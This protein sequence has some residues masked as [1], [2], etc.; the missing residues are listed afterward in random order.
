MDQNK[1]TND[2]QN[3]VQN[4]IDRK[5]VVKA[6]IQEKE[7]HVKHI[8][9]HVIRHIPKVFLIFLIIC[10]I[11]IHL[12]SDNNYD[13]NTKLIL[14]KYCNLFMGMT[15]VIGGVYLLCTRLEHSFKMSYINHMIN[16][17]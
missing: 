17:I 11:F 4:M 8:K 14:N 10:I 3:E 6:Y 7:K 2:V 13:D 9:I 16:I 5:D 1:S 12:S 15:V